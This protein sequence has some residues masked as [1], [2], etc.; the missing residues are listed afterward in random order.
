MHFFRDELGAAV[1]NDSSREQGE[2][3]RLHDFL[4]FHETSLGEGAI[5]PAPWSVMAA[6]WH[7]GRAG[8]PA[9]YKEQRLLK[10]RQGVRKQLNSCRNSKTTGRGK[11]LESAGALDFSARRVIQ[12]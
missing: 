10:T 2:C 8:I 6:P 12:M 7:Q 11:R 3:G 4:Q 5:Q 9:T 1:R